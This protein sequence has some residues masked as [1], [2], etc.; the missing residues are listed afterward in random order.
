MFT[1][2]I[3]RHVLGPME[4]GMNIDL[5]SPAKRGS[6]SHRSGMKELGSTQ[7][8]GSFWRVK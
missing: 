8:A 5:A 4:K 3:P 6:P 1:Y 2:F 7:Y